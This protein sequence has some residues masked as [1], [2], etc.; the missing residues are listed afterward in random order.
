MYSAGIV[1]SASSSKTQW[2]SRCCPDSSAATERS[3]VA[4]RPSG[5]VCPPSTAVLFFFAVVPLVMAARVHSPGSLSGAVLPRARSLPAPTRVAASGNTARRHDARANS[6]FNRGRQ[7]SIDIIARKAKIV[8]YRGR[9]GTAR[10]L[11][12]GGAEGRAALLED[13]G[14]RRRRARQSQSLRHVTPQNLAQFVGRAVDD[15]VGGAHRH[16]ENV[17][18]AKHPF[19]RAADHSEKRRDVRAARNSGNGR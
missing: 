8:P 18:L 9:R 3:I 15:A 13:A 12:R 4:S 10:Q 7:A 2:P 16:R 11:R 5:Y 19:R 1:A 14:G 6:S 17:A